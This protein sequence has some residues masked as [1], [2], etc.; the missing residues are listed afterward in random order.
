MVAIATVSFSSCEKDDPEKSSNFKSAEEFIS[1]PS[2]YQAV[3]ESY[4]DINKGN[5]PPPLAG[6]YL[7]N[8]KVTDASYDLSELKNAPLNSIIT[9]Y[10]QTASGQIKFKETVQGLTVTGNGGYIIGDNGKFS[11]FIE[12]QQSGSEAELPDD[13]FINVALIM[14]G[15][16]LNNGNLT[17]EGLSVITDIQ[18]DK[19]KYPNRDAI[20]GL[21]WKWEANLRLTGAANM[22]PIQLSNTEKLQIIVHKYLMDNIL[23]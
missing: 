7:A 5:N 11:I 12:S 9:L 4:I 16:K 6:N 13:M 2:V 1:N 8:G 19:S 18:A 21:W 15:T 10:D 17:A 3:N 22:S 23:E 14:S 20:K